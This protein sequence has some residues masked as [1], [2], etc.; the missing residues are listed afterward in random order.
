MHLDEGV[1]A[2]KGK[3]F[4][5]LPLNA[6]YISSNVFINVVVACVESGKEGGSVGPVENG[7]S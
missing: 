1:S 6:S 5:L 4:K 2:Y 3:V 7:N